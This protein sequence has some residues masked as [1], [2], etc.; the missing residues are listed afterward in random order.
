MC[1]LRWLTDSIL[2]VEA[3]LI[4]SYILCIT[5]GLVI[6]C[7]KKKGV[8]HA[9][10][11]SN[12]PYSSSS[13]SAS[14]RRAE[15]KGAKAAKGSKEAK[16]TGGKKKEGAEAVVPAPS[17]KKKPVEPAKEKQEKPTAEVKPEQE[18]EPAA[19]TAPLP[20]QSATRPVEQTAMDGEA[21]KARSLKSGF[22][23]LSTL[24]K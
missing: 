1:A 16:G 20:L 6:F 8:T 19:K 3:P 4:V 11:K 5:I 13:S 9:S 12:V 14:A 10:S 2:T 17:L 15:K 21:S 23:A 7:A 18:P 24:S 22:S